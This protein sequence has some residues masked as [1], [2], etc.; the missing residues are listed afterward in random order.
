MNPR[1]IED[2][3]NYD[4]MSN[5]PRLIDSNIDAVPPNVA[6]LMRDQKSR[7]SHIPDSMYMSGGQKSS[8]RQESNHPCFSNHKPL[9]FNPRRQLLL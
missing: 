7:L 6:S 3:I 2:T 8:T 5:H 9:N 1:K 4:N